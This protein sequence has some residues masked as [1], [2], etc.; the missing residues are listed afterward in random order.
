MIHFHFK[1]KHSNRI[2][3]MVK[4]IHP[5]NVRLLHPEDKRK[6]HRRFVSARAY[7]RRLLCSVTGGDAS[8]THQP[9]WGINKSPVTLSRNKP[10][11][12]VEVGWGG[13]VSEG[14]C[15]SVVTQKEP[16]RNS[17]L[18]TQSPT[19][20]TDTLPG[21]VRK[22]S[23]SDRLCPWKKKAQQSFIGM[24]LHCKPD[25][26]HSMPAAALRMQTSILGSIC[27]RNAHC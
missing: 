25:C 12:G 5:K 19:V 14:R 6:C 11:K 27:D 18:I 8:F 7:R 21:E 23:S 13:G 15:S 2:C 20:K 1:A 3:P 10:V 4:I 9:A 24:D 17:Q 16:I 26:R 22:T